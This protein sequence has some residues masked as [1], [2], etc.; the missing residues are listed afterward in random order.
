MS[1]Y[2]NKFFN[3][4]FL[5]YYANDYSCINHTQRQVPEF[6]QVNPLQQQQV[7]I[8]PHEKRAQP[9]FLHDWLI[10][11]Q[12][13]GGEEVG[14]GALVGEEVVGEV[15]VVNPTTLSRPPVTTLPA[16]EGV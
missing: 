6:P 9:V 12:V 14:D 4:S 1:K 3:L 2:L 7:P 5:C 13:L 10:A 16:R 15:R 8:P 11:R